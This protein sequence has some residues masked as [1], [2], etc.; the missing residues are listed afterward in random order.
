[1]DSYFEKIYKGSA[2]GFYNDIKNSLAENRKKFIVTANPEAFMLG[3]ADGEVDRLLKDNDTTVVADGIG[4]VKGAKIAGFDIKERIPGIEIA[5][6]LLE[7]GNELSSS[8]FLFGAK[9]EVI[10][11][12][13]KEINRKYPN[14][15]II[16]FKD[17]Y[18]DN[19]NEVFEEIKKLKPDIVMVALGMPMQEK[20]IY[21]HLKDFDKGI[22]IGVGGSFDVLSGMK[23]RAPKFFIKHNLEWLYRITK[24]PKRLKRFYNNNIKFLFKL[25]KIKNKTK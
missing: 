9:S 5:Q 6:K 21:K 13:C 3:K 11:A 10:T 16:G 4:L 19:K 18:A 20:I 25:K 2:D 24:E 8:V 15:T 17:G 23:I 22:F 1:M 7:Y 14:I 12:L